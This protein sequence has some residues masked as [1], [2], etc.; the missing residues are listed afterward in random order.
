MKAINKCDLEL[1][2]N[3]IA[4][5][6]YSAIEKEVSFK[7]ISMCCDST[8][9]YKKVCSSCGKELDLS[10]IKKAIEVGDKFK[11]TKK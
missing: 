2:S 4:I 8:I 11:E 6:I 10:E 1:G 3:E 5:N 7:Q 9:N